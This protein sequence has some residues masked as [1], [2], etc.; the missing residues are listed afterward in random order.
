MIVFDLII[1]TDLIFKPQLCVIYCYHLK[2]D[3]GTHLV[4]N[5]NVCVAI[6]PSSVSPSETNIYLC[7]FFLI[8]AVIRVYHKSISNVHSCIPMFPS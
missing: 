6:T 5:V 3:G 2:M 4:M 1:P 7:G 8:N